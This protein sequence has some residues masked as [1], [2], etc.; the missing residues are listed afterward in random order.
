MSRLSHPRAIGSLLTALARADVERRK[1]IVRLLGDRGGALAIAALQWTV[2]H[3]PD[4]GVVQA[5]LDALAHL[6]TPPAI[7]AL[8]GLTADENRRSLCVAALA[9]VGSPMVPEIVRGLEHSSPQVR[10]AVIEALTGFDGEVVTDALVTALRDE[11]PSVRRAALTAMAQKDLRSV[12]AHIK[13]L[14]RTDADP[15]VRR[16]AR[17]VLKQGERASLRSAQ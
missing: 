6:A 13:M 8:I 16:T 5:A 7:A 9:R 4:P 10:C 1:S 3:D 12:R 15:A 11:D 14:A 2:T 17:E